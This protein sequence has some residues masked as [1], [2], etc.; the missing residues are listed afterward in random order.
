[1]SVELRCW[2]ERLYERKA[3]ELVLYGRAL[4]LSHGEAEDVLQ[5]TFAALLRLPS[6]PARPEYYCVRCF[7]NRAFNH[8]RTLW[9]RL[10]REWES[11]GWFEP[12]AVPDGREEA[13]MRALATLPV[14]QREAIVLKVWHGCTFE[15]IGRLTETS[16]N[17][18]AGRFRYGIK[19]LRGQLEN[20]TYEPLESDG[21]ADARM[22]T[23]ATFA[24]GKI[25]AVSA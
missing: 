1:M 14:E 25:P 10:T 17:T 22:E 20:E 7:R 13:A 16:P 15:E 4:G 21:N 19:R 18:V 23:A 6:P 8:R 12:A 3:A 2:C 9:R 11:R 5:E 24:P